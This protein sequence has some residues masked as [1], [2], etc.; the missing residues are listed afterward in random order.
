MALTLHWEKGQDNQ[1]GDLLSSDF[2][3]A[4]F[5]DSEG[6]YIVWHGGFVPEI[7]CVGQG[8]IGEQLKLLAQNKEVLAFQPLKLYFA[9]AKLSQDDQEGVEIYLSQTLQPKLKSQAGQG[10]PVAVNMPWKKRSQT[11]S[12]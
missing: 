3:R 6:V 4:D 5:Q 12:T 11:V 9:W 1:W 10:K 7:V 8:K 2:D